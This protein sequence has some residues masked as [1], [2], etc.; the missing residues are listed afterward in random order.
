MKLTSSLTGADA[1]SVGGHNAPSRR[2]WDTVEI[3]VQE[4]APGLLLDHDISHDGERT[5][6]QRIPAGQFLTQPPHSG[7]PAKR[8]QIVWASAIPSSTRVP[9][10]PPGVP[11]RLVRDVPNRSS[12]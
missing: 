5:M 10:L 4:Q 3:L 8:G 9:S 12:R 11:P 6:K 7:E 1:G 2:S